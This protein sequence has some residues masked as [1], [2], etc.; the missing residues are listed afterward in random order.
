MEP[1]KRSLDSVAAP[2][3][4]KAALEAAG[5]GGGGAAA[6]GQV[7]LHTAPY[8][9]PAAHNQAAQPALALSVPARPLQT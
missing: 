5:G 9:Q 8:I 1:L 4:K 2:P 6:V 3:P 7:S